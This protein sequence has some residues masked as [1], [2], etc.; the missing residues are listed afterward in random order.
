MA[1][2]H[3]FLESPLQR[4]VLRRI[5]GFSIYREGLDR[6]ALGAAIDILT[7]AKRPLVIFPEG[8]ITRTNDRLCSLMDGVSFVARSAAKK[9]ASQSPPGKVV[10]HP[11][12]I[13]YHFDGD[14]DAADL[15]GMYFNLNECYLAEETYVRTRTLVCSARLIEMHLKVFVFL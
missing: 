2:W 8:V 4:F 1:S 11:I 7:D 3:L 15:V 10:T 9:R 5:G 12:A 6:Q 14:I 13:R